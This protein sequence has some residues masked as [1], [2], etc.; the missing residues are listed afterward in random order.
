M[1]KSIGDDDGDVHH[2]VLGED[3]AEVRVTPQAA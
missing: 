1:W 3:L 2:G